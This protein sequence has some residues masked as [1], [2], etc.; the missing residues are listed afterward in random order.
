MITNSQKYFLSATHHVFQEFL[1]GENQIEK[2]QNYLSKYPSFFNLF[3]HETWNKTD[4]DNPIIQSYQLYAKQ[5]NKKIETI[6]LEFKNLEEKQNLYKQNIQHF[7]QNNPIFFMMCKYHLVE[8]TNFYMEH[9][10]TIDKWLLWTKRFF[11]ST[12][13]PPKILSFLF[14]DFRQNF[15]EITRKES[16]SF[17]RDFFSFIQY[18][19]SQN[20]NIDQLY[21]NF[22]HFFYFYKEEQKYFYLTNECLKQ[23]YAFFSF[24]LHHS[25]QLNIPYQHMC[26]FIQ[27]QIYGQNPQW[28]GWKNYLKESQNSSS[29]VLFPLEILYLIEEEKKQ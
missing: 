2:I 11:L 8:Y 24:L 27:M 9:K 6:H 26:G 22:Y 7:F 29:S 1:S 15:F 28:A 3:C 23:N 12:Y 4:F 5:Q 18:L 19:S 13:F 10:N 25:E 17:M 16:C 14:H 21:Q 20:I